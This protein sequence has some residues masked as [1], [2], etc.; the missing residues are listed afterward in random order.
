MLISFNNAC[1]A[2]VSSRRQMNKTIRL[3]L[4]GPV[5]WK[6]PVYPAKIGRMLAAVVSTN[7]FFET[8]YCW[9]IALIICV[10]SDSIVEQI[11]ILVTSVQRLLLHYRVCLIYGN[12]NND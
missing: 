10:A 3:T 7:R 2:R 4:T 11:Q 12:R 1:L 5:I 6:Y 9:M 8:T